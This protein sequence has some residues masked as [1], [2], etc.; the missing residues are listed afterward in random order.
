MDP[1]FEANRNLWDEWSLIH[2]KSEV[3]NLS[4]FLAGKNSLHSLE[5]AELGPE[6]APDENGPKSLLHLQCHVGLDTLSWARL[7]AKATGVDFSDKAVQLARSLNEQLGLDVEFICSNLYDLPG[8]LD[9]QFD[10]VYTSYGVLVWLPDIP[11]WAAIA[12]HFVKPGGIFY[13]AEFHPF[14]YIFDDEEQKELKVRYPYFSR[15]DPLEFK[16]QGSYADRNAKVEQ[17]VEYEWTHNL[18]DI[19]TALISAGLRIDYLHEFPYA[20]NPFSPHL[21]EKGEDG[22]WRLKDKRDSIPL[23]YSIKAIRPLQA[24]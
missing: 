16:T 5:L 12:A 7:G 10:I 17:P 2:E 24:N 20:V 11:K 3:Y 19:L 1:F 6:I 23:M 15:R 21:M 13:I 8:R 22:Y 4:G 14:A 18:G 9:A